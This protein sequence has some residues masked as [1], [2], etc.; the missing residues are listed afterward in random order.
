MDITSRDITLEYLNSLRAFLV[1][2]KT[3]Y[4]AQENVSGFL[5]TTHEINTIDLVIQTIERNQSHVLG[6]EPNDGRQC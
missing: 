3:E 2:M 1:C 6:E 4:N 5:L